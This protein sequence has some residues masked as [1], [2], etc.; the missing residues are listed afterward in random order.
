MAIFLRLQAK[1]RQAKAKAGRAQ[2]A[3]HA[4]QARNARGYA[5]TKYFASSLARSSPLAVA[6]HFSHAWLLL[7]SWLSPR[8]SVGN[9]CF[10]FHVQDILVDDEIWEQGVLETVEADGS[11]SLTSTS[12][13]RAWTA[14]ND[15][16]F[17]RNDLP[18]IDESV[19]NAVA[20]YEIIS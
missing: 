7:D 12:D 15:A 3:R 19:V 8:A 4:P 13:F 16:D 17:S 5:R 9:I 2:E 10:I 18:Y 11:S 20:F 14:L 6:S 1:R